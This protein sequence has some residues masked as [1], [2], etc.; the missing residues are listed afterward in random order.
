M[1]QRIRKVLRRPGDLT[2]YSSDDRS[3]LEYVARQISARG[4]EARGE[5]DADVAHL[6][7]V[8][9]QRLAP[10]EREVSQ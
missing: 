3:V 10:Y 1:I 4:I 2:R 9:K 5:D 8:A 7:A 6:L